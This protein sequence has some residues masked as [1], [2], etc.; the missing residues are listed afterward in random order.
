MYSTLS[1]EC[2][3]IQVIQPYTL[4]IYTHYKELG[5]VYLEPPYT[6]IYFHPNAYAFMSF[7]VRYYSV[8]KVPPLR[9]P[10]SLNFFNI[11]ETVH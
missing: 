8:I 5:A 10:K 4:H 3:A 7:K 11:T 2:W 1:D 6:Y 9:P